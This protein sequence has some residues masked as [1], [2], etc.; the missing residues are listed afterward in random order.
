MKL[1]NINYLSHNRINFSE[2]TFYFLNR[3][4]K[5]NKSKIK[6]TILSTHDVKWD[7]SK[8]E[9][10]PVEVKVFNGTNNYLSKIMDAISTECEYSIKLDEIASIILDR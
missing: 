7:L 1:I 5:E 6:L 8:I 2:L 9:G 10:I 3:I 4:K